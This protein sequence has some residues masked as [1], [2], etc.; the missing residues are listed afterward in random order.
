MISL[1]IFLNSDL[2]FWYYEQTKT[3]IMELFNLETFESQI[4]DNNLGFNYI[5]IKP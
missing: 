4:K 2:G 5:S 1:G 3:E